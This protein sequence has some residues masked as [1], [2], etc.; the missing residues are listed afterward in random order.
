MLRGM[1]IEVLLKGLWVDYGGTLTENNQYKKISGTL[2]HNLLSLAE[3]ISKVVSLTLSS[4]ERFLLE[5]LSISI[6]SGRY[7]IQKKWETM[8]PRELPTGDYGPLEIWYIPKDDIAFS[9]MVDKF[10]SKFKHRFQ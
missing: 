6:V 2:E 3:G 5:R 9:A 7:P 1:A 10:K 8:K 4:D